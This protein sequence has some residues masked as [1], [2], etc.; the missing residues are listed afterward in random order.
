MKALSQRELDNLIYH[1]TN[2]AMNKTSGFALFDIRKALQTDLSTDETDERICAIVSGARREI[3][4]LLRK[5]VQ[6]AKKI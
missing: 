5:Y 6:E 1:A 3:D 2:L 4:Y